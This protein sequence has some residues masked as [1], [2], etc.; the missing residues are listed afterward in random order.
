M[1]RRECGPR[2][3]ESRLN[4]AFFLFVQSE[5]ARAVYDPETHGVRIMPTGDEQFSV[6][7]TLKD[8]RKLALEIL[9]L[10]DVE[11][12]A[13]PNDAG[14]I[15]RRIEEACGFAPVALHLLGEQRVGLMFTNFA[16]WRDGATVEPQAEATSEDAAL[17]ALW[18]QVETL[19]DGEAVAVG[20]NGYGP[21]RYLRWR[22]G[23][24]LEVAL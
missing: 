22:N 3:G 7:L 16:F 19:G 4:P 20:F 1:A 21:R 5:G 10:T 6:A 12:G 15:R 18:A 23:A 24:W 14:S 11:R 2:G 17:E 8:A 9:N 13:Q